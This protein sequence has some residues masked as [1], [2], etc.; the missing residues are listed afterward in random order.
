VLGLARLHLGKRCLDGGARDRAELGEP[1]LIERGQDAAG[2][3]EVRLEVVVGRRRPARARPTRDLA[4]DRAVLPPRDGN[5]LDAQS[6]ELLFGDPGSLDVL[7]DGN[8]CVP[9][10]EERRYTLL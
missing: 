2:R 10:D 6:L 3:D 8:R 7:G 5:S 1:A 4:I 9:G